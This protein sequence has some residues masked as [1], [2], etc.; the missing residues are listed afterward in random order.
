MKNF[1]LSNTEKY[2]KELRAGE[3]RVGRG[4]QFEKNGVCGFGG[5]RIRDGK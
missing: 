3:S 4:Q 1:Y 2:C 5:D